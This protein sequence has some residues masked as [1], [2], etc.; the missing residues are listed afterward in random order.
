MLVFMKV[1]LL[2]PLFFCSCNFFASYRFYELES[3]NNP[4]FSQEY[5]LGLVDGCRSSLHKD[6][7]PG[8]IKEYSKFYV[9]GDLAKNSDYRAAFSHGYLFCVVDVSYSDK[10]TFFGAQKSY[11]DSNGDSIW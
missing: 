2:C 9:N 3:F 5:H 7:L 11:L 8:N 4:N 6:S 10:G 1:F